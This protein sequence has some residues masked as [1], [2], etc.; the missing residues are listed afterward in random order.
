MLTNEYMFD[1]F[2]TWLLVSSKD[3]EKL[4]LTIKGI[5]V[6]ILPVLSAV[7]GLANVQLGDLTPIVDAIAAA[8]QTFIAFVAA[9]IALYGLVRKV[10][11]TLTGSHAG[12]NAM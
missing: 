1:T 10:I 7:F 5:L 6:G 2:L 9:A 11:L 4:S 12:L 8:V 3:P